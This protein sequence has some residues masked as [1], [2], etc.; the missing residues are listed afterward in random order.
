MESEKTYTTTDLMEITGLTRAAVL[1]CVQRKNH[2]KS[3][4]RS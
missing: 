1:K 4:V 2:R 3:D